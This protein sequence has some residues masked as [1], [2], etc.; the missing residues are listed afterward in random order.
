MA[1]GAVSAVP[2]TRLMNALGSRRNGAEFAVLISG[3]NSCK[4]RIWRAVS[5][6]EN[7]EMLGAVQADDPLDVL[8]NI[9]AAIAVIHY[10]NDSRI[11]PGLVTAANKVRQELGLADEAWEMQGNAPVE[12]RDWWDQWIRERL[13]FIGSQTRAWVV[14]WV[15]EM[16][17][18]WAVREGQQAVEVLDALSRYTSLASDM[19]VSLEG[20][21]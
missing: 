6:F 10:L 18:R 15:R 4:S 9:R 5:P 14:Q 21:E 2:F 20:L 12:A 1:G 8:R 17:N 3:H 13:R 19:E 7:G 11:H 16:R